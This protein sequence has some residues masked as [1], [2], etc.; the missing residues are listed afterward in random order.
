MKYL[1]VNFEI[2][3]TASE[4]STSVELR[5]IIAGNYNG[6]LLYGNGCQQNIATYTF[7]NYFG[8]AELGKSYHQFLALAQMMKQLRSPDHCAHWETNLLRT[9]V[10]DAAR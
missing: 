2:V 10:H 5:F 8:S 9:D 6:H 3:H 7:V 4:H 1:A